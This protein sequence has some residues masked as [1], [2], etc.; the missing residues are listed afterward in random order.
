MLFDSH[1]HTNEDSFSQEERAQV[2]EEI[3]NCKEL[4]YS[5]DIGYDIASSIQAIEDSRK[6]DK[7]Y[8]AVGIHPNNSQELGIDLEDEKAVNAVLDQLRDLSKDD[9]VVAIG[10]IGLDY[11]YDD[12]DKKVQNFWFRKQ[13]RLAMEL[14]MPIA[15]HS[16]DADLDTFNCLKEE[17]A[18][19]KAKE[20][21]AFGVLIHCA[22]CSAEFAKGY[23]RE[24]AIISVAGPI[25]Y[26]NNRRGVELVEQIH[27]SKLLIET[28]SPYLAPV[29]MRGK[30]NRSW[31]VEYV[32]RKIAEIKGMEYEE[33]ARITCEN[34][35]KFYGI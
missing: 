28:D 21:G 13:I 10:E 12:T 24:G 8:V 32:A 19:E 23:V 34:A 2:I 17:G 7:I 5:M 26:K 30:K 4:S 3:N 29:P 27:I 11:H 9:K 31:Y 16:R 18:F 22:S 35:K 33:V 25:T 6:S 20:G 15:I 14:D 1:S